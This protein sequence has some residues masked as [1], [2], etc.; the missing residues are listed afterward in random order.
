MIMG[1]AKD[2]MDKREYHK[3]VVTRF[4]L[5]AE[6]AVLGFCK[7]SGNNGPG[8]FNCIDPINGGIC[9]FPGS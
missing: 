6:E 1:N 3:P 9:Q 8:A 7:S 2:K 4:P 5:K